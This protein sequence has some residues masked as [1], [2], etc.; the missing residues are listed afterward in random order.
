MADEFESLIPMIN[1]VLAD[2]REEDTQRMGD[3]E[4]ICRAICKSEGTDPEECLAQT[5]EAV[6]RTRALDVGDRPTPEP[7]R[8][9]PEGAAG[10]HRYMESILETSE[11]NEHMGRVTG[12]ALTPVQ[13]VQPET[14]KMLVQM[15][16]AMAHAI[17]SDKARRDEVIAAQGN[18]LRE[19]RE[20]INELH[21]LSHF[22]GDHPSV[23]MEAVVPALDVGGG[24]AWPVPRQ[25]VVPADGPRQDDGLGGDPIA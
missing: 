5:M 20:E 9:L 13:D 11:W 19:V 17:D 6:E 12:S 8:G 7:Q 4:E 25:A 22:H 23:G 21:A 1:K 10:F 16:K 24:P 14:N 15:I 2:M 3:V 18:A